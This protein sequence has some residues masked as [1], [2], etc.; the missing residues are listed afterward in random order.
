MELEVG[1][2][3]H[4]RFR[5]NSPEE[6]IATMGR[7]CLSFPVAGEITALKE[8]LSIGGKRLPNR[9]AAQPMEGADGTA[10]GKPG[11]LTHRRYKRVAAGGVGL[12]WFEA[13]AVVNEGRASPRQLLISE[14]N[15]KAFEDLLDSA[16]QASEKEYGSDHRPYTVLQLTH[17]GRYSKL[18]PTLAA[19]NPHLDDRLP[20]EHR[21]ISDE[22]LEELEERF[23]NAALMAEKI[24]FDA[25]DIKSCHGYLNSELLSSHTREGRYGGSFENR[26]RFLLNIVDKIQGK[27]TS[28]FAVALRLNAYDGI[29]HPYGWGVS[30]EDPHC[31]DLS[32]PLKLVKRLQKR[33]VELVNITAGVPSFKPHINR[34]FDTG[35]YVPDEHPL[36]GIE[37]ML[38]LS[39][40]IQKAV[41]KLSV[42]ATGFSWLREFGALCASGG[43]DHGWFSLAGFGRQIFAYPDFPK[44]ILT[45]GMMERK[46]CC[47]ACGKCSE[48]MRLGGM[49]GCV[50]RDAGI[51]LPIYRQ[52]TKRKTAP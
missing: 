2:S 30:K 24:G 39:R 22:E 7:M 27:A 14:D 33:G 19:R 17:S 38:K 3:R 23:V 20:K 46:K 10:D 29:P 52:V 48:I 8:P 4:G 42:V 45:R 26:T 21:V 15:L 12:L 36:S 34:V 25:V 49:T 16:L 44:D 37:R 6:L 13:T 1:M 47:I 28:G 18:Q 9:I 51:Y 43:I 31:Y 11:E 40:G 41:P 32:E 50:I 5:F 35:P